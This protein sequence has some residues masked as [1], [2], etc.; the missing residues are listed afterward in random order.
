MFISEG[1]AEAERPALLAYAVYGAAASA[2]TCAAERAAHGRKPDCRLVEE[3]V[4]DEL[5]L[6]HVA[7]GDKAAMHILFARHRTRVLRFIRRMVRDPAIADDLVSQVFLDVWRS[8]S[9]F[10]GRARVTTVALS[11]KEAMGSGLPG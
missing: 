1:R 9:R 2:R 5:L 11:P 8:A 3:D 4:S 10:E 7:E 6:R